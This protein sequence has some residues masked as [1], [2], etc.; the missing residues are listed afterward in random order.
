MD[1]VRYN[2]M[3]LMAIT[4]CMISAVLCVCLAGCTMIDSQDQDSPLRETLAA[5]LNQAQTAQAAALD[6]WDRLIF[7]ETV[8][9]QQVIPTPDPVTLTD[10]ERADYPQ[11]DVIQT[12]LNAAIQSLHDSADLWNIECAEE[13]EAVPLNLA[14]EGRTAALAAGESL[15]EASALLAA[16][17]P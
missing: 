10:R 8:S 11:A 1:R 15:A 17:P 16:W 13:R 5:Q 12:R 7:G 6:L 14:R 3:T 9:C 2:L 4:K